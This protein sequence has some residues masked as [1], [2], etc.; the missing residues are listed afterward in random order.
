[1]EFLFNLVY[2]FLKFSNLKKMVRMMMKLKNV[3]TFSLFKHQNHTH[4][5]RPL[6]WTVWKDH[7]NYCMQVYIIY[8]QFFL[9]F[10]QLHNKF[11]DLF[12]CSKKV[13]VMCL[14]ASASISFFH[15]SHDKDFFFRILLTRVLRAHI[16]FYFWKFF[17][18]ELK[19]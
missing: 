2:L 19:K 8:V 1:M 7:D 14:H 10:F 18:R 9:I 13:Q 17:F 16:N 3:P 4:Q 5:K 12:T 15:L 11:P 6:W